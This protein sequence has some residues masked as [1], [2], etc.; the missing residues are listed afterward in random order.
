MV[1][2]KTCPISDHDFGDP[3][4]EEMVSARASDRDCN[5]PESRLIPSARSAGVM[6]GHGPS[7]KARRAAATAR[8]M[9]AG[10]ASGTRPMTSS[11]CGDTTSMVP[12]PE[13]STH[14]PPM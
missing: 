5:A 2:E 11:V 3:F 1:A 10:V 6:R 13:D 9:S 8:S 14:S 7:S 4:S 12:L